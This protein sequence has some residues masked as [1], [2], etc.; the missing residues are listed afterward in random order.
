MHGFQSA[1]ISWVYRFPGPAQ[2]SGCTDFRGAKLSGCA[3][4]RGEQISGVHGFQGYKDFR[5]KHR[6]QGAQSSWVCT[7]FRGVHRVQGAQISE[8]AQ[9][10]GICTHFR[11]MHRVHGCI[12]FRVCE[13]ST[14]L[15]ECM[16]F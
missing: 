13:K 1:Q 14:D 9:I 16:R 3:E 4:F 2:I 12:D 11:G 15:R 7:A 8:Y 6:F 5:V 10:L